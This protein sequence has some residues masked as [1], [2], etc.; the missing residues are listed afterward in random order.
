M[1]PISVEGAQLGQLERDLLNARPIFSARTLLVP[2]L[3]LIPSCAA[4]GNLFSTGADS[5]VGFVQ[6]DELLNRVEGVHVDCELSGQNVTES[7]TTLIGMVNPKFQGDSEA[8]YA[9]LIDAI[10]RSDKQAK[11]LRERFVPLQKTA[12][13][14]FDRWQKDVEAIANLSMRKRSEER[15]EAAR[16]RYQNVI[17]R[18]G[19]AMVAYEQFNRDLRDHSLYLGNDFNAES[20]ALI[21]PELRALIASSKAINVQFTECTDAC[22]EYVRK[23]ASKGQVSPRTQRSI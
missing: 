17:T 18:V 19:P 20:V 13:A 7:M 21:E 11:G 16:A 4:V 12:L 9:E 14:V 8:A 22:Q 5:S 15:M 23:T 3:A 2:L 6:V 1:K 10:E